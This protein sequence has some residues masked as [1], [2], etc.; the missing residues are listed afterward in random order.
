MV[1]LFGAGA[2]TTFNTNTCTGPST[3]GWATPAAA[4]GNSG[5][6][7]VSSAGAYK[8]NGT[9]AAFTNSQAS[10]IDMIVISCALEAPSSVIP[11]APYMVNQTAIAAATW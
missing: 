10:P 7:N 5:D 4:N 1:V 2:P 11:G 6:W 8:I 9:T 3:S